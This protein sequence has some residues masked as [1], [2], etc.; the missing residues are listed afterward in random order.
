MGK[1]RLK[2]VQGGTPIWC[3]LCQNPHGKCRFKSSINLV[4]TTLY[5]FCIAGNSRTRSIFVQFR[6]CRFCTELNEGLQCKSRYIHFVKF[7]GQAAQTVTLMEFCIETQTL[8]GI[9]TAMYFVLTCEILPAGAGQGEEDFS[10]E[11]NAHV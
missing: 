6:T 4:L 1:D 7:S 8:K 2:I 9:L 3:L 10:A 11:K 5:V